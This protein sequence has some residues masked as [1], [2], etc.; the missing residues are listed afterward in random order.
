MGSSSYGMLRLICYGRLSLCM[1]IKEVFPEGE[2]NFFF[3]D[4]PLRG[5]FICLVA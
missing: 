5:S 2:H 4:L 1:F 3:S